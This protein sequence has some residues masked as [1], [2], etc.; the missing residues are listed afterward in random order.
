MR[1]EVPHCPFDPGA[2]RGLVDKFQGFILKPEHMISQ[3]LACYLYVVFS[4]SPSSVSLIS[5]AEVMTLL[6]AC[7][8]Q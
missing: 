2:A 4:N 1:A 8:P 7:F 6:P 3:L 5:K